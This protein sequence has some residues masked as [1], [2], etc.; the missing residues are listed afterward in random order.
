M[1]RI[2]I[3]PLSVNQAWQGKRY[4]TPAYENYEKM[5][6]LLPKLEIPFGKLKLRILWGLSSKNADIDNP[7]KP[8]IDL[9]QKKYGFN[10]KLIY[11]LELEKVAVAKGSEFVDFELEKF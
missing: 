4:K 6:Y 2:A 1:V 9:L 8:F 3:K 11:K 10:D 7:C 5:A